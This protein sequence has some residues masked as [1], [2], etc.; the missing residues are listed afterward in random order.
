MEHGPP[1]KLFYETKANLA[2]KR[3][4]PRC[5]PAAIAPRWSRA[6]KATANEI[7]RLMQEGAAGLNGMRLLRLVPS[8]RDHT[9][10]EHHLQLPWWIA[11]GVCA[12][13]EVAAA[14]PR[15]SIRAAVL[16]EPFSSIVLVP[17]LIQ[18]AADFGLRDVRAGSLGRHVF[19]LREVELEQL[20]AVS[21]WSRS[22]RARRGLRAAATRAPRFSAR[23]L[24]ASHRASSGR[25]S[26]YGGTGMGS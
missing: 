12:H 7:L 6:W 20:V 24:G 11:D 21:R 14:P 5:R 9:A 3:Y 13:G 17:Y 2:F 10:L 19:H 18:P 1:L 8:T 16:R 4:C 26:I 25:S 15:A 23:E 22:E